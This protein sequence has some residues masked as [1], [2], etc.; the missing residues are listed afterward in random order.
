MDAAPNL[1]RIEFTLF[2][3]LYIEFGNESCLHVINCET[4]LAAAAASNETVKKGE[5]YRFTHKYIYL[6]ALHGGI[7]IVGLC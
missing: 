1:D 6:Y 7:I 2:R 3:L 4:L 5:G